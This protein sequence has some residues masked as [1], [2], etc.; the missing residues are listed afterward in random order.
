MPNIQQV[1]AGTAVTVE[2]SKNYV[3]REATWTGRG[4]TVLPENYY[5]FRLSFLILNTWGFYF[6]TDRIF[7][8]SLN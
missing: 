6:E 4:K 5:Q 8:K 1:S 7:W 3:E 2:I